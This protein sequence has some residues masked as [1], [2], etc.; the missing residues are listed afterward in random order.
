MKSAVHLH[1]QSFS[2][3]VSGSRTGHVSFGGGGDFSASRLFMA[4]MAADPPIAALK[5]MAAQQQLAFFVSPSLTWAFNNLLMRRLRTIRD[6]TP[7][8][9]AATGDEITQGGRF[10]TFRG[11]RDEGSI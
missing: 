1:P 11:A 8:R 7:F 2:P 10:N 4:S 9:D 3:V 5:R 6:H